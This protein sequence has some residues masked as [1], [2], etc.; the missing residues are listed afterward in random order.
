MSR[1]PIEIMIDEACG[2]TGPGAIKP[3]RVLDVDDA[4]QALMGVGDLAVAW[5]AATRGGDEVARDVAEAAL[6]RAAEALEAAGWWAE[7]SASRSDEKES[8]SE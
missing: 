4:A 7:C 5:L 6:R 3:P 8:A 2:V 1:S